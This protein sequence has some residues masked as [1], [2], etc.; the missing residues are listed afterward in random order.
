[1][2]GNFELCRNW[3][4]NNLTGPWPTG[5][6]GIY[7]DFDR[8]G[9]DPEGDNDL[10]FQNV[11]TMNNTIWSNKTGLDV[12]VEWWAYDMESRTQFVAGDFKTN[13]NWIWANSSRGLVCDYYELGYYTEM[14]ASATFGNMEVNNNVVN[15]TATPGTTGM[16]LEYAWNGEDLDGNGT[17]TIGNYE[18]NN[19]TVWSSGNGLY[20][21]ISYVGYDGEYNGTYYYGN[22]TT[23]DNYINSSGGRGIYYTDWMD[24]V[25]RWLSD[26]VYLETGYWEICRNTIIA[27]GS[28]GIET[29]MDD[30]GDYLRYGD[31]EVYVGDVRI[32]HNNIN[33]SGGGGINFDVYEVGDDVQES[34]MA[35]IGDVEMNYN[36]IVSAGDGIWWEIDDLGESLEDAARAYLGN[37]S[38]NYNTVDTDYYDGDQG[39]WVAFDDICSYMDEDSH[40]EIG[41]FNIIGNTIRA[42]EE[43]LNVYEI[44]WVAE[45]SEDTASGKI[46]DFNFNQNTIHSVNSSAIKF[47]YI[48]SYGDDVEDAS[49]MATGD[50]NINDNILTAPKGSG[51]YFQSMYD[52]GTEVDDVSKCHMG[53]FNFLRNNITA[54]EYGIYLEP[55]QVAEDCEDA[56]YTR[57]GDW[58]FNYNTIYS[59]NNTA[60]HFSPRDWGHDHYDSAYAFIGNHEVMHNYLNSTNSTGLEDWWLHLFGSQLRDG[61]YVEI[62]D[63]MITDN[64]IYSWNDTAM[65]L[66]P[67][68]FGKDADDNSEVIAGDYL[69]ANN[70]VYSDT[71]YSIYFN[72][73]NNGYD[74]DDSMY[75]SSNS[76]VTLGDMR[77]HDNTLHSGDDY[78]L[79]IDYYENGRDI[80]HESAVYLG[81]MEVYRNTLTG[82]DGLYFNYSN[83]GH[84]IN[85]TASVNIGWIDIAYNTVNVGLNNEG[86]FFNSS[87]LAHNT[88]NYSE[89]YVGDVLIHDNDI[90]NANDGIRIENANSQFVYNYSYAEIAGLKVFDNNVSCNNYG[91]YL[92]YTS[93]P[94]NVD[95]TATAVWPAWEIYNNIFSSNSGMYVDSDDAPAL[96]AW[97]IH[98]LT[99]QGT[100][101][102]GSDGIRVQDVDPA[103]PFIVKTSTFDNYDRGLNATSGAYVRAAMCD[104]TTVGTDDVYLDTDSNAFM[105]DCIFD[106]TNVNYV[107]ALSTLDIG[108]YF[109]VYTET[110]GGIRVPFADL[111]AVSN[112]GGGPIIEIDQT[113]ANGEAVMMLRETRHNQANP[114]PAFVQNFNDHNITATKSVNTGWA[115]P[116]VAVT[117][118]GGSTI[119]ILGDGIPPTLGADSSDLFAT[120]GDTYRFAVSAGDDMGIDYVE[121]NYQINAGSWSSSFMTLNGVWEHTITAPHVLGTI[122]YYFV[123][124]DIGG[125]SFTG[126]TESVP[127]IDNDAPF[128][129]VDNTPDIVYSITPTLDFNIGL[130]DNIGI[131]DVYLIF[132]YHSFAKANVTMSGTGPYTYAHPVDFGESMIYYYVAAVDTSGN[133]FVGPLSDVVVE[134]IDFP[135]LLQDLS[136]TN[137]TTGDPFNFDIRATDD[138]TI[139]E[140]TVTYWFGSGNAT[141]A[142]LTAGANNSYTLTITIPS[143]SLDTLYYYVTL[144]DNS[145]NTLTTATTSV[146]VSDNDAPVLVS[147]GSDTVATTG[148]PFDFE[149]SGDDNIGVEGIEVVYWFGTG[150]NATLTLNL[151][152]GIYTG[153]ITIPSN[154][155]D[156]LHYYLVVT[157]TSGNIYSESPQD[158]TVVDNDAPIAGADASDANAVTGHLFDFN[159]AASDNI[160]VTGAYVI[161]WFG[162]GTLTNLTLTGTGPYLLNITI[163]ANSTDSLHYFFA[164]TDAAGNWDVTSVTT[165]TVDDDGVPSFGNDN[166]PGNTTENADLTFSIQAFDNVGIENIYVVYWT[167][168]EGDYANAQLMLVGGYYQGTVSVPAGTLLYYYFVATDEAGN[169]AQTSEATITVQQDDVVEE[170]GESFFGTYWWII[171][172]I[173]LVII[174]IVQAVLNSRKGSGTDEEISFEEADAAPPEPEVKEAATS[175]PP[176]S[177]VETPTQTP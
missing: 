41:D 80:N 45:D 33:N 58:R 90:L 57:V 81:N 122:S 77:L 6:Y 72:F 40:V 9:V 89:L 13:G 35:Q 102:G 76:K 144:V 2:R 30:V 26:S 66:G 4:N 36:T 86:I 21:D 28:W 174:I 129:Y 51:I 54:W 124:M 29:E 12:E 91:L 63:A 137:A 127:I 103:T 20:G 74:M 56:G 173:I 16:D 42:E 31:V 118:I 69:V 7:Y 50:F 168:T 97:D 156:P 49:M 123:V 115:I 99:F 112:S 134:D 108:W 133:W 128:G 34:G 82:Y 22:F 39:I 176:A 38:C 153:T 104:F 169:S 130:T 65:K 48:S 139:V 11:Y 157:D 158:V 132:W 10:R 100:A 125:N 64:E 73:Y 53:D 107:D 18:V 171:I 143:D 163:P 152:G 79:Y 17:F 101:V 119:I 93:D 85:D 14:D 83:I 44:R 67:Y 140:H 109:T 84:D 146:A 138:G 147:D 52:I 135:V 117:G 177:E 155:L 161:Y 19:N 154:S 5:G 98:D 95:A 164:F 126:P 87:W 141:T 166:T 3:I 106:K 116:E 71:N 75:T 27:N 162:T 92:Q 120:T 113:D 150:A 88:Y 111:T 70:T 1:M 8:M 167:N 60:L 68:D 55:Y 43:G 105:L 170:P 46:G 110:P 160:G 121:V 24:D 136:D 62:G 61:S 148:D 23:N 149:A 114:F 159:I 59:V 131:A 172:V 165:V 32:N 145:G 96:P 47:E 142:N 175:E 25:G 37:W 15:A 94:N 151:A 78:A